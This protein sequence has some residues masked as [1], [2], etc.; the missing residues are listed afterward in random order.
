MSKKE[1][2]TSLTSFRGLF[3][4]MI[5]IY[6][7]GNNFPQIGNGCLDWCYSWGGWLGNIFFF[8]ASGF[9]ISYGYTEK[10]EEG[11]ISF[12]LFLKRRIIKILPL[13]LITNLIC[14]G[15]SLITDGL[16]TLKFDELL[17]ILLMTA[18]G[19]ITDITLYNVPT[20]F[21]CVLILIYI[22]YYFVAKVKHKNAELYYV[23]IAVMILYGRSLD[24]LR[25]QYPFMRRSDGQ[26]LYCF[27]IGVLLSEI[28]SSRYVN[29]KKALLVC[30]NSLTAIFLFWGIKFGMSQTASDVPMVLAF[31]IIP[32]VLLDGIFS[33]IVITVMK[34]RPLVALGK[35]SMAL[36]F[37]HGLWI[38]LFHIFLNRSIV[39]NAYLLYLV[40][41]I[42]LIIV[43][44][45]VHV[46]LEPVL[47]NLFVKLFEKSV[48]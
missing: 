17:S 22:V 4:V 5:V 26:A 16:D 40:F 28:I 12:A 32:T 35:I 3:I 44:G 46:F 33:K 21:V 34:C 6:H 36:F 39:I 25:F 11:N 42:S 29:L 15:I 9:M 27:F 48:E 1:H 37:I 43:S 19:W 14:L 38:A 13:Y 41:W 45:L 8:M 20:W 7:L 30:V 23:L 31:L 24:V 47:E 18:S 2:F 10:I